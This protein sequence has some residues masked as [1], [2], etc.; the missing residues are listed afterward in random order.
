MLKK[1]NGCPMTGFKNRKK[2]FKE[3]GLSVLEA[4]VATAIVGIGFIAI[5]NMVNYSVISIDT[6][7]E[8]TKSNFL[9]TMI[10]EDLIGYN[11]ATYDAAGTVKFYN[12]LHQDANKFHANQCKSNMGTSAGDV[13]DREDKLY[14]SENLSAPENKTNKWLKLLGNNSIIKCKSD[15]NYRGVSVVTLC[16]WGTC[17]RTTAPRILDK[18]MYFGKT[19][20]NIGNNKRKYLYFQIDYELQ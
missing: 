14:A 10:A 15:K 19:Q 7:A 18:K 11:R 13:L 6:S 1:K 20:I 12:Y 8:R 9:T 16:N 2:N 4:I 17:D 3:L 5:F